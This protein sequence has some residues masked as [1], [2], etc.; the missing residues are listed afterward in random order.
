MTYDDLIKHFG[1]ASATARALGITKQAVHQWRSGI[2][3]TRQA[4]IELKTDGALTA[5]LSADTKPQEVA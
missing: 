1:S 5:D 3:Q 2:T 4:W